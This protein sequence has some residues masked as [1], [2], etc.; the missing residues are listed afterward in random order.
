ML[1]LVDLKK[2]LL[3]EKILLNHSYKDIANEIGIS[4]ASI[5]NFINFIDNANSNCSESNFDTVLNLTQRYFNKTGDILEIMKDYKKRIHRPNNLKMLLEFADEYQEYDF[6]LEVI[7]TSLRAKNDKLKAIATVYELIYKRNTKAIRSEEIRSQLSMLK[8]GQPKEAN[9]LLWILEAYIFYDLRD[10]HLLKYNL[11]VLDEILPE[12]NDDYVLK[13]YHLRKNELKMRYL[14]NCNKLQECRGIANH[15]INT[16]DNVRLVAHSLYTIGLSFM[17][18]SFSKCREFLGRSQKLYSFIDHAA[19]VKVINLYLTLCKCIHGIPV[20]LNVDEISELD[21]IYLNIKLNKRHK[22]NRL[23]ENY[24]NNHKNIEEELPFLLFLKGLLEKNKD[25]LWE[26]YVRYIKQGDLF[27][28]NF[29]NIE[30][31]K[32]GVTHYSFFNNQKEGVS[33]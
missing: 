13:R 6:L 15:I 2:K 30:L 16:T 10:Y 21:N 9:I 18:E 25:I 7:Q 11:E 24:V 26:S 32:M 20:D 14:L 23:L 4:N 5:T 17:F 8:H 3:E 28:A 1:S 27:F 33:V 22:A 31:R 12:A 19:S 29:P